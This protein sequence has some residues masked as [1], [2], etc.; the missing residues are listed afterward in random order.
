MCW[1]GVMC[2][3]GSEKLERILVFFFKG[4]TSQCFGSFPQRPK[5]RLRC[6]EQK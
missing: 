4:A 6:W 5:L 3:N 2:M 1:V